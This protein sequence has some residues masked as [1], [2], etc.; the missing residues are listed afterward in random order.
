MHLPD[1]DREKA[2]HEQEIKIRQ[3][4]AFASGLFQGDVTIRTLLESL[5][6]GCVIIDNSG[7][8][9]L[10]NTRAEQMFGYTKQELIGK[11]HA[12][13]IPEVLR[14]V[15]EE[16]ELHFFTEPK[17]R[18]MGQLLDLAARRQDGSE[19]PVEISL[20]FIETINGVL[21]LA[22]VSD[23]T[24]RKEYESSLQKSEELFRML[25]EGV[26]DNA[27]FM[28]DTQGNVLS[29]NVGAEHLNGYRTEEI[30]G[31]LFSCFYPEEDRDEDK[32]AKE[33]KKAETDGRF[34]DEGW[35][36]RKDGSRFWA[37][38]IITVLCEKNGNRRG[39]SVVTRDISKWKM[40]E[41]KIEQL[42]SDLTKRAAEL[43]AANKDLEAFNYMAAHDLRIPLTHIDSYTQVV[44]ELCGDR[45]DDQC[46]EY[47]KGVR[48]GTVNM[49]K[50]ID[51]LLTFSKMTHVEVN[52]EIIDLSNIAK[53]IAGELRM[54]EPERKVTFNI[55][56]G[57]TVSGDKHLLRLVLLNLLGNA[58][59]YTAKKEE[60][61]IELGTTTVEG[62][63]AFFIRDNGPGFDMADADK[64]FVPFHRLHGTA[65]FNGHGIGLSTVQ[66]IVQR[67]GGRVWA[68]G[69]VGKGAT[70][71]FTL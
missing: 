39:F 35:R 23:I 7:T 37:H 9:L 45:L 18:P 62:V 64:L 36:V 4:I 29:W 19:F 20:S 24:L 5:A 21:V 47:L 43:D 51:T 16:H 11:P 66:R 2:R 14:K 12:M 41:E 17:I 69:A 28:L 15:H 48:D 42:N 33:L 57:L 32:P 53:I 38:V 59:K 13:L 67:H 40:A 44:M 49:S 26:E 65:K 30:T 52:R 56:E 46:K 31:K 71:Y 68:E 27:I 25:V 63:T 10:V 60:S 8:I 70:F 55:S 6:E 1:I 22:F 54:T 61:F 3:Q 34:E 58:W 50:L